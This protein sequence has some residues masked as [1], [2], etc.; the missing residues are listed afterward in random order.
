MS[1]ANRSAIASLF[2]QDGTGLLSR[3]AA[4]RIRLLRKG[5][6]RLKLVSFVTLIIIA[7]VGIL[8]YFIINLMKQTVAAKSFEVVETSLARIA[9]VSRL[10]LL[11]RNYENKI[12]LEEIL[13][14]TRAADIEGLLDVNIFATVKENGILRFVYVTGFE[15]ERSKGL[16]LDPAL[17]TR[18]MAAR[19]E[20]II[21]DSYSFV[22][23]L[24][25]V[26]A[27]RYVKPIFTEYRNKA[28]LLGAVVMVYS[29]KAVF[30]IVHAVILLSI[31]ITLAVLL[32]SITVACLLGSRFTKP[33]L[34]M[35]DA[36]SKLADGNLD[37]RLDIRTHDEIE[38]LGE[39]FNSMVQELRRKEMMQKFISSSTMDMIEKGDARQ[40][41][42]GGVHQTATLFFSDIRRFTTICENK[43][44]QEV[45]AIANFYLNLQAGIIQK[46]GGDI[47]KFV[48]DEVM[49]IFSGEDSIRQALKAA[50][51]IQRTIKR[52]N[53]RRRKRGLVTVEVGIGINHGE[54]V[55]G[56]VGAHDRMDFTAMG[57]VVNL[58]AK[59]C[60]RARGSEI[61]IDK[62]S[63]L[64]AGR[65]GFDCVEFD[66][67][68]R[69]ERGLWNGAEAL[70]VQ[71]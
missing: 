33:I 71:G 48:G 17:I 11:E 60:D 19:N 9:D 4:L 46:W 47:D 38:D 8:D 28:Q 32:V 49:A 54:V 16:L 31:L 39:R 55:V 52:E 66:A 58:A 40:L 23:R 64:Q 50:L 29:Q 3:L 42:L 34:T 61:L 67:E 69:G 36:A 18:L 51:E 26:P 35:A 6:L 24:G 41:K 44:P 21:H 22:D 20:S 62:G 7:T 70:I 12:N 56:N 15:P 5:G 45:V 13:Q 10:A 63:Y 65:L 53:G 57:S 14:G 27:Y 30:G 2:W 37:V 1:S 59:L 43:P 68:A 25:R